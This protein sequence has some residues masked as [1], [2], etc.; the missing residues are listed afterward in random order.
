MKTFHSSS[1]YSSVEEGGIE[2]GDGDSGDETWKLL[3][4]Q[5]VTKKDKTKTTSTVAKTTT[6]KGAAIV[7]KVQSHLFQRPPEATTTTTATTAATAGAIITADRLT[8]T[9]PPF[10][11]KTSSIRVS[12]VSGPHSGSK[13]HLRPIKRRPCPVGSFSTRKFR[14]HGISLPKD[15]TV[16]VNQG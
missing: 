16:S 13:F 12:V 10:P 8:T 14:K 9:P 6:K 11:I 4:E 2:S 7:R 1:G 15:E 5:I 3:K